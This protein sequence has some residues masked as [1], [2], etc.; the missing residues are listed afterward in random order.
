MSKSGLASIMNVTVLDHYRVNLLFDDGAEKIRDLE[1]YLEGPMFG[2]VRELDTFRKVRVAHGA[3]EWP[4]G[5]D[6]CPDLLYHD[7]IPPWAKEVI[8]RDQAKRK[9]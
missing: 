9:Q 7:G 8:E 6:I 1:R 5:A 3:L 4:N 2:P